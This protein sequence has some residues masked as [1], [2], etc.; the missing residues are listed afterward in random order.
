MRNILFSSSVLILALILLRYLF[1]NLISRRVQYALWGL[2]LL[3][4]LLP[5]SFPGPGVFELTEP[6]AVHAEQITEQTATATSENIQQAQESI[7]QQSGIA[8]NKSSADTVQTEDPV[9]N[10]NVEFPSIYRV[11]K[12]IW[13]FGMAVTALWVAGS[14]LYFH[15]KLYQARILY[16]NCNSK[17]SVYFIPSGLSSPCLFG[18]FRPAIYL[19]PESIRTPE[20]LRHILC[21]EE[22]HARHLDPLWSVLRCLCLVIYWFDPLVWCAAM[23]SKEDCELAC[24]EGTLHRLGAEQRIA[25]GRTLLSLVSVQRPQKTILLTA[26]TMASG[27]RKLRKRITHIAENRPMR[28]GVLFGVLPLVVL[29]CILT[30]TGC[31]ETQKQTDGS[32]L[33]GEELRYFNEVYFAPES[34]GGI[35]FHN[36][37]L[38]SLYESPQEMDLFELF[39]CGYGIHSFPSAQELTELGEGAGFACP[40]DKLPAE[41]LDQVFFENT[42][43]HLD[44]TEKKNLDHFTYL[45]NTNSYYHEHGDTNYMGGTQFTAGTREND[46]IHLYYPG[47][48]SETGW[49]CLTL[50]ELFE[51][52]HYHVVSNLPFDGPPAVPTVYD[53]EEGP[54]RKIALSSLSPLEPCPVEVQRGVNDCAERGGGYGCDAFSLQV[55][56]SSEDNQTYAAVMYTAMHEESETVWDAGKFFAYPSEQELGRCGL[57]IQTVFD[58]PCAVVTWDKV[59]PSGTIP[60]YYTDYY[61]FDKDL[62]PSLLLHLHSTEAP[63]QIDLDGNGT[64]ELV[65]SSPNGAQLFF[66]NNGKLYEAD[67]AELTGLRGDSSWNASTH[68]LTICDTEGEPEHRV[69]FDGTNLLIFDEK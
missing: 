27:K 2:V 14:N 17:L 26:T 41:E 45:E 21:H 6:P 25:Y 69:Y 58:R 1:R 9:R 50:R 10:E 30:F 37:F 66:E 20:S 67:I 7:E 54:E 61:T 55:Y 5:V 46:L 62:N 39:Y 68:C 56:R 28:P 11:L 15:K 65:S 51:P 13:I 16:T 47:G 23:L 49:G 12:G 63:Q 60:N 22:T 64:F 48:L 33:P 8:E 35:N 43:L 18:L 19:T 42:G 57:F 38:T 52:H 4:L 31:R 40:V 3:R 34:Q 32:P 59:L 36:Q 24:D 44:E 29:L 53:D